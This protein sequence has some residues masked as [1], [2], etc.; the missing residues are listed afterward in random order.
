MDYLEIV[1]QAYFKENNLKH[2][3]KYFFREFKKAEKEYYEADEFFGGC[4]N[5][6]EKWL[7]Y[8]K[9]K[10]SERKSELNIMLTDAKNGTLKFE[11]V[12]GIMFE[13]ECLSTIKYC[14]NELR[15]LNEVN[16]YIHLHSLTNGRISYNMPYND[17]LFIRQAILSAYSSI[18]GNSS[19]KLHSIPES[20]ELLQHDPEN[21]FIL[22]TIED[23]LFEFK[24]KMSDKDYNNLVAALKQYFNTGKFPVLD[25]V[26]R[27]NGRIN[28]KLLG[29][30][31]N[32]IFEAMGKGIELELLLFAKRYISIFQDVSFDEHNFHKSNLYKYFTSKT[33]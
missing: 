7:N 6:I 28:K 27:I 23:W 14:E 2:M 3:K 19:D 13:K 18:T 30:H 8:S 20:H 15:H 12:E 21:D 33:K 22:S 17:A 25:K 32:R 10:L 4:L 24:E 16:F 31:L 11:N 29:W 5:V 1:I 9:N 26:I